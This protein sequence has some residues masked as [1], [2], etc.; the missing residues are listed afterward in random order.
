MKTFTCVFAIFLLVATSEVL[1]AQNDSPRNI[2][3]FGTTYVPY[4]KH[5]MYFDDPFDFFPNQEPSVFIRLFYAR[6]VNETLRLGGYI[7]AAAMNEFTDQTGVSPHSFAKRTLGIDWVAKYPLTRLHLQLGGYFG[8][9]I[10]KANNWDKLQGIDFGMLA[11]PGYETRHFGVSV[12]VKAGFAPYSS[13]GTPEGILM[14]APGILFQV[15][16]KL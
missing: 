13:K 4:L 16:G 10:L 14:Y 3:G 11:G 9:S 8:Y 2:A 5:G 12:M 15:Y 6:K 1:S 7:E